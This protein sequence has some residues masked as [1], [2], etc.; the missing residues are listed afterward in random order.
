MNT[1]QLLPEPVKATEFI[2]KLSAQM[3]GDPN[4]LHL[5]EKVVDQDTSCAECMQAV[6]SCL[7]TAQLYSEPEGYPHISC[8]GGWMFQ[9]N[10]M[11]MYH[12]GTQL[13]E[14]R[15]RSPNFAISMHSSQSQ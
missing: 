3:L 5:M 8:G 1:F 11:I 10:N 14:A 13:S 6:V 4:L 2:R 15:S 7:F 12:N 9:R